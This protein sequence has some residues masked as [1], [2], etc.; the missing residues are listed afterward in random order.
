V[1]SLDDAIDHAENKNI[2]LC[3]FIRFYPNEDN[4]NI[5]LSDKNQELLDKLKLPNLWISRNQNLQLH[6]QIQAGLLQTIRN[7]L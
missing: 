6:L 2:S 1:K 4:P 5:G 7:L 3:K